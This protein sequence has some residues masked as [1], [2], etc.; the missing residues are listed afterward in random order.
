MEQPSCCVVKLL[1]LY[2][3][4]SPEPEKQPK[5]TDDP[6]QTHKVEPQS[7]TANL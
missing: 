2:I 6:Y 4:N 5:N 7:R 3:F 1:N